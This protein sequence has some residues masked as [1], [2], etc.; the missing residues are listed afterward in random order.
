LKRK[1]NP[2]LIFTSKLLKQLCLGEEDKTT[3]FKGHKDLAH[4]SH[5][6]DRGV[7]TLKEHGNRTLDKV[8]ETPTHR[9]NVSK[10][11]NKI[12]KIMLIIENRTEP[13][14]RRKSTRMITTVMILLPAVTTSVALKQSFN[15]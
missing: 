3:L 5:N 1:I 11:L 13:D 14:Q 10:T 4:M 15:K 2:I 12:S 8:L 6:P 9:A 7:K